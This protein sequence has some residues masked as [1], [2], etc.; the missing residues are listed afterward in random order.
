MHEWAIPQDNRIVQQILS[1]QNNW[2]T[3]SIFQIMLKCCKLISKLM[4]ITIR[5]LFNFLIGGI[6][7]VFM[8]NPFVNSAVIGLSNGEIVK[9]TS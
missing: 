7:D 9:F 3:A 4:K 8:E 6:S 2:K 5:T 1:E